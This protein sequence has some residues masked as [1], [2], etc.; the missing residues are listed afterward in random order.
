MTAKISILIRTRAG[1]PTDSAHW[2]KP[3]MTT[4]DQPEDR[5]PPLDKATLKSALKAFRKRLKL[6]RL[7]DESGLGGGA[8]TTGAQSSIAGICPPD[9]FPNE[10]WEE[11][12]RLGRLKDLGSGLYALVD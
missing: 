6:A 9:R 2:E 12:A 7:D 4:Q 8:M 3:Q 10:V 5:P 1:T 11:L